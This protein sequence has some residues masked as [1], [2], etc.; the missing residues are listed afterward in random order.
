MN[1]MNEEG[2][3]GNNSYQ[4]RTPLRNLIFCNDKMKAALIKVLTYENNYD[5]NLNKSELSLSHKTIR[6][7]IF[8]LSRS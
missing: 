8:Y 3:G 6:T 2:L 4:E 7:Q 5:Y 1:T